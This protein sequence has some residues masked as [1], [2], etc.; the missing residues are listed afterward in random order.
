MQ[1]TTKCLR[2]EHQ[3]IL[4]VLDCFET[5]MEAAQQSGSVEREVFEPFLEFFR[6]FADRCHHCKE[7][8]RLFPSLERA[9]IPREGGPI[10]VMLYEHEL[11]R[12][13]ILAMSGFLAQAAD[14]A[15]AAT[16]FLDTG[17]E[18]LNLLRAHISK[19]DNVLFN[20]ADEVIQGPQLTV[21]TDAYREE[22]SSAEYCDTLARCRAIADKLRAQYGTANA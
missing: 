6:G 2:E 9:G 15:A 12:E 1:P 3:L 21:L 7:E 19:E 13:S 20:M 17:R 10:G 16:G 22:E 18:Y 8:D 4:K 11:A 14:D 5:A